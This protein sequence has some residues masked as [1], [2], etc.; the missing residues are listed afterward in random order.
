MFEKKGE[1]FLTDFELIITFSG[2]IFLKAKDLFKLLDKT[3][4]HHLHKLKEKYIVM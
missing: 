3:S 2:G 1:V 4:S